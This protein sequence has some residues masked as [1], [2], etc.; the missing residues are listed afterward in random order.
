MFEFIGYNFFSGEGALQVS[1]S[2]I[3]DIQ[4]T[5]V[6]NAIFDHVNI[7]KDT[8][9]AP[10]K[11]IP[12]D[13]TYDTIL[14]ANL[15]GNLSG[16]N[17]EYL[18]SNISG[19]KIKRRVKGGFDWLTLY[20]V[21]ISSVEDLKFVFEDFLNQYGVEYEYA[22]VPVTNGAE[23][24]YIINSIYSKFNGVFIGSSE[25]SYRFLYD[26]QYN[27]VAQNQQSGIFAPLGNK[28]PIIVSNGDLS[29]ESGG[30]SATILNDDYEKTGLVDRTSL[31][32]KADKIKKFLTN[33][34]PKILKDWNGNLWVIMVTNK[35]SVS[36]AQGSGMGI[37][38]VQFDWVQ[39]GEPE[40]FTELNNSGLVGTTG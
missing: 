16:G 21:K 17:L 12:D 5:I 30:L 23:G 18:V 35:V 13:W 33:K 34:K 20:E 2:H 39:I 31:A 14:N 7:T 3:N 37:P 40:E 24:E 19:I 15:N 36:Y 11:E 29:Y 38:N 10:S 1:P 25:E 6:S 27:Q 4:E 22:F 32:K 8:S 26:V 9:I 28:Y